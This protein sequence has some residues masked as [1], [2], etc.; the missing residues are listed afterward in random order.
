MF[1]LNILLGIAGRRGKITE[2]Q[3]WS[4]VLPRSAAYVVWDTGAKNLYRLGSEGM[5]SCFLSVLFTHSGKNN[6]NNE[7][8]RC[9]VILICNLSKDI[10]RSLLTK[11][12]TFYIY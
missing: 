6:K 7:K 9:Q 12:V 8:G 5:V 11:M 3:D 4:L 1:I 10:Q 2:I